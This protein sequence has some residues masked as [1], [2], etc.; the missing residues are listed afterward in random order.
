MDEYYIMHRLEV[1][2]VQEDH[3]TLLT[4]NDISLINNFDNSMF[5]QRNLKII[6]N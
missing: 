3:A 6:P 4:V 5:I 1:E 2:N